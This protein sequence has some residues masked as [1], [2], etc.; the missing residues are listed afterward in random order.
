LR[1]RCLGLF[2]I[3]G[4]SDRNGV[5]HQRECRCSVELRFISPI[6]KAALSSKS[7]IASER[8]QV[9]P[10]IQPNQDTP[11]KFSQVPYN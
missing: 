9:F 4:I 11:P 6:M 5:D 7:D 3:A 10:F 8:V 1:E 2:K